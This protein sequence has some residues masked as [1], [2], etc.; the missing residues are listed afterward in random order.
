MQHH[1]LYV[2]EISLI[3]MSKSSVNGIFS[4]QSVFTKGNY[5]AE[6]FSGQP[7][8]CDLKHDAAGF[9]SHQV[10]IWI[11][12]Q[13]LLLVSIHICVSCWSNPNFP[14]NREIIFKHLARKSLHR[15]KNTPSPPARCASQKFSQR[16][17]WKIQREG[18]VLS[19]PS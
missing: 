5:Y 18:I 16:S 19:S 13:F 8:W 7:S 12:P 9:P 4:Q 1:L 17:R 6:C 2:I 3:V 10:Y 11:E 15:N 14:E